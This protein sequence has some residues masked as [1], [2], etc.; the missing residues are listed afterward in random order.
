MKNERTDA[1]LKGAL[2]SDEGPGEA[3][4]ERVKNMSL[5]EEIIMKKSGKKS[6]KVLALAVAAALLAGTTIFAALYLLGPADVAREFENPGLQAAF[7]SGSAVNIN[8]SVVSGAY[9]FTLLAAVS[10][11]ELAGMPYCNEEEVQSGKTYAVL[12]IAYADGRAMTEDDAWELSFF[13]TP[14]IKGV[15][16]TPQTIVGMNG[17]GYSAQVIDG[18][19]YRITE[20]DDVASFA[21]KGLYFGICTGVFF[22]YGAFLFDKE[23]GEFTVNE[24]FDGACA[25]FDLP[26]NKK[27]ANGE[28]AAAFFENAGADGDG[29]A[30][31]FDAEV[32][33]ERAVVLPE[34]VQQ[35]AVDEDSRLTF[36]YT[37]ELGSVDISVCDSDYFSVEA[38]AQSAIISVM[39]S[40]DALY[41][42]RMTKD[43]SGKFTGMI[44][45]PA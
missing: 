36:A 37:F 20:C 41:A 21:D 33:W 6:F 18:V 3:L 15:E 34:S 8:K 9:K 25:L 10:G 11:R 28:K 22:D 12:A 30:E 40:D 1:L 39:K 29:A 45:L 4:L 43:A 7:S 19:L 42:V 44:M 23:T 2:R 13:S 14:L 31:D 27:L 16:P 17:G 26:L 24:D 35:L 32:D 38:T 5:Q